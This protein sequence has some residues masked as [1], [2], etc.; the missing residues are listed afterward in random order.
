MSQ[1]FNFT[2]PIVSPIS[3]TQPSSLLCLPLFLGKDGLMI[4]LLTNFVCVHCCHFLLLGIQNKIWRFAG[5]LSLFLLAYIF[6]VKGVSHTVILFAVVVQ[7][8]SVGER[9]DRT[10]VA[11][12]TI[13]KLSYHDFLLSPLHRGIGGCGDFIY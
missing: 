3:S 5:S 13:T 12:C 4:E 8:A 11:N 6:Y 9:V 10:G 2:A 1:R 7:S